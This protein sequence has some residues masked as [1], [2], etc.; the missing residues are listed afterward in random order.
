MVL[1][2]S[3]LCSLEETWYDEPCEP[4]VHDCCKETHH[5]KA[6]ISLLCIFPIVFHYTKPGMICPVV[7]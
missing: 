2:V 6:T 4:V 7:K 5:R 3:L 1:V